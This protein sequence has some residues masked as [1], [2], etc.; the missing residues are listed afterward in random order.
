[1][2]Q[3]TYLRPLPFRKDQ[4]LVFVEDVTAQFGQIEQLRQ[5]RHRL[6]ASEKA[7]HEQR[8]LAEAAN[9]A[10]SEFLAAMSHELR[11]PLNSIIGFSELLFD[12]RFGPLNEKQTKYVANVLE[13]GRGLLALINDILDLAKVEAGRV[14]VAREPFDLGAT[15]AA[16]KTLVSPMAA[17]RNLRIEAGPE[18]GDAGT[19]EGDEGKVRQILFN[20]L[21]NAI[22]FTPDGGTIRLHVSAT[23]EPSSASEGRGDAAL[24]IR[25]S[26]TGIGIKPEHHGLV[27]ERFQQIDSSLARR[28]QGTG[29]GLTLCRRLAE[30]QGGT[31]RVESEG[32]PGRGSTFILA[33]PLR[34][35]ASVPPPPASPARPAPPATRDGASPARARRILVVEDD[36]RAYELIVAC[37][38]DHRHA[39]MRAADGPEAIRSARDLRPD[40]VLLDLGLPSVH[41]LDVLTVVKSDPATRGIPVVIVSVTDRQAL[42][43]GLDV[44]DWL[45]KPFEPNRLSEAVERALA[46]SP[47]PASGAVPVLV[48]E[49][50]PAALEMVQGLLAS[51]GFRV[52]T[53]RSGPE[54]LEA[55]GR[56]RPGLVLLDLIL[57]GLDGFAVADELRAREATKDVPILVITA[58]TL[59]LAER[60]R[61]AGTV[62]TV[63]AKGD[64]KR[65]LDEVQAALAGAAEPAAAEAD[66]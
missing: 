6:R 58:K 31:L 39:L 55:A 21:T 12:E 15:I 32:V 57:P 51:R 28:Q 36:D 27:F 61:L 37:L 11:T 47:G 2:V 5:E 49:D 52:I 18:A 30:L 45:V 66:R 50:D 38:G 54:A 25:V 13:S 3:K 19:V 24:E 4:V 20:L 40:V 1:M 22:K 10:K 59:S 62:R 34:R 35:G 43:L 41:G 7:L 9:R 53:A 8:E 64:P 65:L 63:I 16:A 14:D 42:P 26:D 56:H 44:A 17:R 33:L 60:E 46:A 23:D 29:L 48:V